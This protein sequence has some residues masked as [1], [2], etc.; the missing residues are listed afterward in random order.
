MEISKQDSKMIKGVAVLWMLLI[1]LFCRTEDLPYTPLLWLRDVPLIY[2]IGLFGDMCVPIF[3]FVTGYAHYMQAE[4]PDRS[5]KR[6]WSLLRFFITFW[7]IVII[8]AVI[9]LIMKCENIPFSPLLFIL[10][11]LTLRISYN[12]AWWYVNTYLLLVLLQPLLIKLAKKIPV[13]VSLTGALCLYVVGYVL[14]FPLADAVLNIKPAPIPAAISLCANLL[15][16]LF[17]YIVGAIFR[18]FHIVSRLRAATAHMKTWLLDLL[19]ILAF[20]VMI[21]AHGVVQS[22]FVAIFTGVG[23]VL[24]LCLCRMPRPLSALLQFIGD[25]STV[26]WLSHKF[27]YGEPFSGL[28]FHAVYVLP[29][30]LL[31]LALS[32]LTSFV[33]KLISKPIFKLLPH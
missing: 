5:A 17:P 23:T 9:G 14:R 25:H 6:W 24:L 12:G 18:R 32:L 26:I 3:C 1:H 31:L 13:I 16:C 21:A 30:F 2:Y 19:I 15:T 20:V 4:R 8:F 10:N 27:F 22:A 11:C 7:L 29:V 33:I 28:V